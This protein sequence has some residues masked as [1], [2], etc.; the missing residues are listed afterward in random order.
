MGSNSSNS[1]IYIKMPG[2]PFI[3]KCPACNN[4]EECT[5]HHACDY[6]LQTIDDEVKIWLWQA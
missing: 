2:Y 3:S 1:S 6:G 5:W 4:D